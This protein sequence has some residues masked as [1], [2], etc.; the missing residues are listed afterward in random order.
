M[1]TP[2]AARRGRDAT[3]AAARLGPTGAGG[4]ERPADHRV[5]GV[6]R[7][8]AAA[9]VA[10]PPP[11]ARPDGSPRRAGRLPNP[12][13]AGTAT[14]ATSAGVSIRTATRAATL[15]ATRR[16]RHGESSPA[17]APPLSPPPAAAAATVAGGQRML[18]AGCTPRKHNGGDG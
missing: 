2:P 14:A 16:R 1:D 10:Q 12:T 9:D 7:S 3:A 11:S 5:A 13:A 6:V 4:V 8:R 18:A 15:K 17:A